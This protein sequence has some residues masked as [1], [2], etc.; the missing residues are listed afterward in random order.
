MW[1]VLQRGNL[2]QWCAFGILWVD[3]AFSDRLPVHPYIK[4][5]CPEE[6]TS[7]EMDIYME[8]EADSDGGDVHDTCGEEGVTHF[9]QSATLWCRTGPDIEHFN[10]LC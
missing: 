8:K 3:T 9:K 4:L 6:K 7:Y 5:D 1:H 2:N 10:K